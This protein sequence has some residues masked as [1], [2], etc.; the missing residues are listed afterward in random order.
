MCFMGQIYD[1]VL[2]VKKCFRNI[3]KNGGLNVRWFMFYW[4]SYTSRLYILVHSSTFD[5]ALKL[6]RTVLD[7]LHEAELTLNL[8]KSVF[9]PRKLK[10]VEDG[11]LIPNIKKMEA[12]RRLKSPMNLNDVHSLLRF[13]GYYNYFIPRYYLPFSSS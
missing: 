12:L 2:W 9:F 11:K 8:P 13:R 1:Y 10:Y 7:Y 5:K 6:R 4:N 3:L